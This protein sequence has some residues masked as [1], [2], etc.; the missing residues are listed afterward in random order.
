MSDTITFGIVGGYG[1]T[2]RAV[3]SG[4][5]NSCNGEILIGGR[6]L[7][8]GSAL[9]AEFDRRVSAVHLDALDSRSLEDFCCRSSI[10]VNC[11]G[12][13]M[14]LAD[15]VAQAALRRRCHY[16]DPGGYSFVKERLLPH[17]REIADLRLSFI[18][19][20]GWIPGISEVL[21]VYADAQARTQ[22]DTVESVAVYFGDGSEWST[23]ALRDGVWYIRHGLRSPGHFHKGERVRTNTFRAYPRADLGG[24]LGSGRFCM[25]PTPELD[26]VGRRLNHCD[27]FAYSY[28]AGF[29]A[30]LAGA[31]I[32]FLPLPE[33]WGV[34]LV[35]SLFRS[36][37]LPVGG[38]VVARA[39]G[40]SEG[41]RL[42]FAVQ[43]FYDE[44]RQYW[45]NGLVPA[46]LARMVAESKG[47]NAGVHFLADAVDPIAF[48][49]ELR[50]SGLELRENF[51]PCE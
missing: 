12:R 23:T 15:R 24:R 39:T 48:M 7:A 41:C 49:T 16:I 22:M 21:P 36:A 45:A 31:L 10:I 44:R 5:W 33:R 29:R 14:V 38:F 35:R 9:A 1:A 27:F 32:A 47:V 8:K 18:L 51:E 4:L 50:K 17:S 13:V 30:V 20:A 25:F 11:A 43:S 3:V 46:I 6:D 2:G 28:L 37:R 26:E 40:R 42:A 19:S 34:R